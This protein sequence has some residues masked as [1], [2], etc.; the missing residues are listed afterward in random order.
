MLCCVQASME[1][2]CD[3]KM[4]TIHVYVLIMKVSSFQ[5]A[6]CVRCILHTDFREVYNLYGVCS[7]CSVRGSAVDTPTP[8]YCTCR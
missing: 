4:C 7:L 1:L 2:S 8:M 5:R 3:L 6:L